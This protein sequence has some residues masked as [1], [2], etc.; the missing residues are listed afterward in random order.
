MGNKIFY[1]GKPYI[2]NTPAS[3]A[4]IQVGSLPTMALLH[5]GLVWCHMATLIWVNTNSGKGLLPDSISSLPDPMLTYDQ[6]HSVALT[7]D[8]FHRQ[9]SRY[10]FIK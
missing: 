4:Y 6:Q 9:C 5:Y 2:Y 10:Q 8:Q 7:Y 1:D 3:K